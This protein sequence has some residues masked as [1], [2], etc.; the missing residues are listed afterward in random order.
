MLDVCRASARP[1]SCGVVWC[2][3]CSAGAMSLPCHFPMLVPMPC[4]A[5]P[6]M[7]AHCTQV[8]IPPRLGFPALALRPLLRRCRMHP[9]VILPVCG[10]R[11]QSSNRSRGQ[12]AP[13]GGGKL[14]VLCP[15]IGPFSLPG[16]HQRP[17]YRTQG[18]S[19]C[20]C[21]FSEQKSV[22]FL[23]ASACLQDLFLQPI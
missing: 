10:P 9:F 17:A 16:L 22:P 23:S 11:R 18:V 4:Q 14:S 21:S 15:R 8:P 2:E 20:H 6:R 7:L 12:H 19:R 13:R 5:M 1:F 3:P